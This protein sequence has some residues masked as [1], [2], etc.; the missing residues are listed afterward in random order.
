VIVL[1]S[2]K[3]RKKI[4]LRFDFLLSK[5]KNKKKL[6]LNTGVASFCVGGAVIKESY[7]V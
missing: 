3:I 4:S 5:I 6:R 1:P 7:Q 2:F